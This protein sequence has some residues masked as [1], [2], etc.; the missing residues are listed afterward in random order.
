MKTYEDYISD[1][2]TL[3]DKI[4]E[5]YKPANTQ[6]IVPDMREFTDSYKFGIIENRHLMMRDLAIKKESFLEFVNGSKVDKTKLSNDLQE[7]INDR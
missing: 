5:K 4:F 3:A 2:N 7:I 1:F 6:N